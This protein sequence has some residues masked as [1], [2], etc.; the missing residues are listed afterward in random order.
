MASRG[1]KKKKKSSSSLSEDGES[2]VG[3]D[4]EVR[5]FLYFVFFWGGVGTLVV[6]QQI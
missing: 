5:I 1:K 3:D 6:F 4:S 2:L